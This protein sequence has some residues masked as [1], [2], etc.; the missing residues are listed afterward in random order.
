M[1]SSADKSMINYLPFKQDIGITTARADTSSTK[2]APRADSGS[3]GSVIFDIPVS[4]I[5]MVDLS[6][7]PTTNKWTTVGIQGEVYQNS[8][9]RDF[10][11]R[12]F[13][14]TINEATGAPV[15]LFVDGAAGADEAFVLEN[16][17]VASAFELGS[18]YLDNIGAE[19]DSGDGVAVSLDASGTADSLF[20]PVKA[21]SA[22]A[23]N[24]AAGWHLVTAQDNVSSIGNFGIGGSTVT[25]SKVAMVIDAGGN[26]QARSWIK[27]ADQQSLTSLEKGK[28]YFV[29]LSASMNGFTFK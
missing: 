14:V 22:V 13:M 3:N 15:S 10:K 12:R 25:E 8:N 28:A 24:M 17:T 5:H 4:E 29:Y 23:Q 19:F 18:N 1:V 9:K 7:V 27:G 2:F 16:S 26:L 20:F 11:M 6:D 21:A